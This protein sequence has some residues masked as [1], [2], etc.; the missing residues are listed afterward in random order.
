MTSSVVTGKMQLQLVSVVLMF[1]EI[2]NSEA[3]R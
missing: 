2:E 3:G 1:I